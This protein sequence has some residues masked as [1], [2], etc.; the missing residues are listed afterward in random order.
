[1]RVRW[2]GRRKWQHDRVTPEGLARR[3]AAEF[4][5]SF[6]ALKEAIN[7]ACAGETRWEARVVSGIGALIEFA[8]E[9]PAAAHALTV[10]AGALAPEEGDP[11]GEML[12]YF[13]A[14]LE[15]AVPGP[16][17]FPISSADGIVETT[18][19]LI[20]GHLLAGRTDELLELGPELVYLTLVPYL[21]LSGAQIWAATFTPE[22]N[23]LK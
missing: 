5:P 11:E 16:M 23:S 17:L 7:R 19:I 9:D 3:G 2:S 13:A 6:A 12:A 22:S 21:G 15:A 4:G 10:C 20:K 18:A 1:V 8:L 14:L